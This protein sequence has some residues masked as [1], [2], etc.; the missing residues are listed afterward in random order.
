MESA[1][2]VSRLTPRLFALFALA[3]T[4]VLAACSGSSVSP[5]NDSGLTAGAGAKT[6]TVKAALLLPLT[7]NP[8]AQGVAK[9]MKQAAE[10]ALFDFDKSKVQLIPKDTR[11]T[12]D[13]ARLAAQ[14]AIKDGAE[15]IIGPLFAAEV[16]AVS[17]VAQAAKVPV[18]AFSSDRNVAGNGVYLLSFLPGADAA[19]V[20]TYAA[21]K[22]KTRFAGLF[23]QTDLGKLAEQAFTKSVQ[24]GGARIVATKTFSA[25]PSGLQT[26]ISGL[27]P[28]LRQADALFISA[29]PDMLPTLA[30]AL[31]NAGVSASSLQLLGGAQWDYPGLNRESALQG[32]WFAA[33][34]PKGWQD[35]SRKYAETYGDTPPR[36]AT[37]AYDA[38]SLTVALSGSSGRFSTAE[39]TRSSGFSGIDGLFRLRPDGT[40]E[41]GL[42]IMQV[43]PQSN[44]VVD[45][46]PS[47]FGS[48]LAQY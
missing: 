15:V 4:L 8:N 9:A 7:G 6:G 46:A 43:G 36:L 2:P 1:S 31:A 11:G 38:V 12:P 34:T 32:A 23:P 17:S 13:G 25:D 29:G 19:R 47:S 24:S 26:A 22:G 18:L 44:E 33:P 39:L 14:D 35:F 28:T 16:T 5:G 37:L 21:Q 20:I 42:A 40:A 3:A 10:L 45:P 48:S 30:P 41:R 27:A